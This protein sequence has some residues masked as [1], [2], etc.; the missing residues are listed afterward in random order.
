M[1]NYTSTGT[2]S[3]LIQCLGKGLKYSLTWMPKAIPK[4]SSEPVVN[5][6]KESVVPFNYVMDNILTTRPWF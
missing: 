4:F 6:T 5:K 2:Y 1:G 3:V